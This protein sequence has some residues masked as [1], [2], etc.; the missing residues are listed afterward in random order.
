MPSHKERMLA[1]E[2]YLADDAELVADRR[3]CRMLCEQLNAT[4]VSEPFAREEILRALLGSIGDETEIL[5]PFECDY[6]YQVSVGARTFINFGT[7]ILDSAPVRI[8]DDVQIGPGVQL[9]TPEHPLEPGE[10]RTRVEWARPVVIGDGVWLAAGVIVC[11]GVS[12]G[13]GSV[14]G[15]G[16]VVTRDLPERQ[17][18]LGSP[19]R[20]VRPV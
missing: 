15:A 16:S 19:C 1:G 18:C 9:V 20:P 3:R 8:G 17:L 11:P 4:S 13:P 5:S 7:V 6:G 10:R 2:P 14:V 12:I